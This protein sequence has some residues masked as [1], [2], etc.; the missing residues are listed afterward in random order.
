MITPE[1]I[2]P[3]IA[4][5]FTFRSKIGDNKM[6]NKRSANNNTGFFNGR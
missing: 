4:G 6:I 3:M 5:I 1:I 2:K